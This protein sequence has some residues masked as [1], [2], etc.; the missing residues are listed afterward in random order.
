MGLKLQQSFTRFVFICLWL[1]CAQHALNISI[2]AMNLWLW[3]ISEDEER[4]CVRVCVCVRVSVRWTLTLITSCGRLYTRLQTQTFHITVIWCA[5]I[6]L[7]SMHSV[8]I[9]QS[10]WKTTVIS[11]DYCSQ[12]NFIICSLKKRNNNAANEHLKIAQQQRKALN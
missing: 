9:Y 3:T 10:V 7:Y 4:V 6:K 2:F 11:M 5:A 1:Y 12:I 8:C